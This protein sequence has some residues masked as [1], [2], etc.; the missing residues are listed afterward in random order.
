M[1]KNNNIEDANFFFSI[2]IQTELEKT[3]STD[4]KVFHRKWCTKKVNI[5]FG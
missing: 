2:S 1:K 5:E 3:G 4:E